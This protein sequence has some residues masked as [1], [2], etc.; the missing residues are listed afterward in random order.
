VGK[1]ELHQC[2]ARMDRETLANFNRVYRADFDLLGYAYAH[3]I[4]RSPN[5]TSSEL[6]AER[7]NDSTLTLGDIEAALKAQGGGRIAV[8]D[9]PHC[10][11]VAKLLAKELAAEES[12]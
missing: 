11:D 1:P 4:S 8:N 7:L 12:T 10:A 9:P 5:A 3:S 2:W 6:Y